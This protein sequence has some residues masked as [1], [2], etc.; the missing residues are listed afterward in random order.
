MRF[1]SIIININSNHSSYQIALDSANSK[2]SPFSFKSH[3]SLF[4]HLLLF[5]ELF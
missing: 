1:V 5:T 3:D 2:L 4:G